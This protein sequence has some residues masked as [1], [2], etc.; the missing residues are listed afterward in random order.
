MT[1]EPDKAAE[2]FETARPRLWGLAYRMLGSAADADDAVQDTYLLW[3][4]ADRGTIEVP[5]AWLTTACTRRCI[6]LL[7]AAHRSRVDYVGPWLPEPLVA[8][9]GQMPS[10]HVEMAS[11]LSTAF[12]L[13][14]ERLTPSERAAYLLHEVFDYDYGDVAA[15]LD[16]SEAACRQLVSRA[17]RH[18]GGAK[19]R[20]APQPARQD[21]LLQEFLGALRSGAV[22]RLESLLAEDVALWADGGGKVSAL[23]DVVE[24]FGKVAPLLDGLWRKWWSHYDLVPA[25]VN[26]GPGLLLREA[27]VLNGV[28]SLSIGPDGR[29]VGIYVVRNPDKLGTVARRASPNAK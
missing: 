12:L 14:L 24:G 29:I 19:A 11:T 25:E 8:A 9:E 10:D 6:D 20:F 27:G 15:A 23:P 4:A 17:R 21:H 26:G 28:L 5:A 3:Q 2:L 22:E 18:V 16:K 7:R 13:L 1:S